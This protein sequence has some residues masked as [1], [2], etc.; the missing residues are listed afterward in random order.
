M[1]AQLTFMYPDMKEG[2]V[3]NIHLHSFHSVIKLYSFV[4]ENGNG[5]SMVL[6]I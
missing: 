4:T 5:M 3:L 6:L 1:N 2:K